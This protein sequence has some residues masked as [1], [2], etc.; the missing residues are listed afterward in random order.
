MVQSKGLLCVLC[1]WM[2]GCTAEIA[3]FNAQLT[4]EDLSS[5]APDTGWGHGEGSMPARVPH[6]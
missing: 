5:D 6:F 1:A 2:F 3:P 4:P